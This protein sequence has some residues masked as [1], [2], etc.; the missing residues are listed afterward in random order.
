M[1]DL[2]KLN[3]LL[4]ESA[5]QHDHLCP[6]QVIGVRMGMLA[7]KLLQLELPRLDKQLFTFLETDGCFADGV[8]VSTGCT[9]GHRTLRLFD[10]GKAAATFVDVK[11]EHAVR[12]A[13]S[14][15]LR[16]LAAQIVPDAK[17]SWHAQ[18]VAYQQILDELMFDVTW[19]TLD[20]SLSD[21]ISR[22]G[23]RVNC[24]S[25][26]EEIINEREVTVNGK[27]FCRTCAGESY[28]HRDPDT[29]VVD[30]LEPILENNQRVAE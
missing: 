26:G 20:L 12:I 10:Y 3:D 6:R 15:K 21:L 11:S 1:D 13:P 4:A 2:L 16:A 25:C 23:M 28:Y 7:G 19:V 30:T 8:T 14:P 17:S 22:H 29:A 5:R 18:L 9:L 24:V 27:P